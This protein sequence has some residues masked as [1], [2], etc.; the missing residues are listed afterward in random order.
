VHHREALGIFVVLAAATPLFAV[1]APGYTVYDTAGVF[2]V[3][4]AVLSP[5]AIAAVVGIPA[6]VVDSVRRR[7][8]AVSFVHNS[9]TIALAAF[10]AATAAHA[11]TTLSD[12]P[13]AL[14]LVLAVCAYAATILGLDELFGRFARDERWAG[15]PLA[16]FGAEASLASLGVC[17]ATLVR[18][19]PAR[20]PFVLAPLLFVHRLQRLPA[21]EEEA[22]CDVKTG[23]LN[24][25]AFERDVEEL[26]ARAGGTG[27]GLSV[28]VLDL[29]NLREINNGLGHLAGDAVIVGVADVIR[30]HVRP[31]DR[32]SRFGGEEFVVA[33]VD[34]D[35]DRACVVAERLREAVASSLFHCHDPALTTRATVSI[36]I[37]HAGDGVHGIR[38]L[39]HVADVALLQAKR[40]GR[41]RIVDTRDY[42][43]DAVSA[44]PVEAA[45]AAAISGA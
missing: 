3:A 31:T 8:C 4:A 37:A 44:P 29:D 39:L 43:V 19:H 32:A 16:L 12:V 7:T 27:R 38:D 9:A 11:A 10:A 30:Q 1:A 40:R 26:L 24:M 25:R 33:L 41:N 14:V 36:G 5:P 42:R 22:A 17:L 34:A 45:A 13:Q 28:L 23:L 2:V 18:D 21:L 35:P 15:L 20:A 6:C